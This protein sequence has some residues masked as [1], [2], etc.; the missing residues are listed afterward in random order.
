MEG[1]AAIQN[2]RIKNILVPTDFSACANAASAFAIQ[3]AQKAGA[4][5]HFLHLQHTP[6][7]WVKLPKEKE[8]RYPE[9]LR[10]IGP[11]KSELSGWV[12][13][14]KKAGVQAERVLVSKV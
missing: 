6:V 7:N 5:V 9:T 8:K 4:G 10:A 14:T 2:T 13:K 11:A 3:L 12:R 1:T